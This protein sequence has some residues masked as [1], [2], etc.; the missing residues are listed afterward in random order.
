[1]SHSVTV[2]VPR[3]IR[4]SMQRHKRWIVPGWRMILPCS[5]TLAVSKYAVS[6]DDGYV[7][8]CT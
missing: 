5:V 2:A 3:Y 7:G 4:I 1:M 8:G 6:G